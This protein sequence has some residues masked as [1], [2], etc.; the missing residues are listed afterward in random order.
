MIYNIKKRNG[1]WVVDTEGVMLIFESYIAAV[2]TAR[3][4]AEIAKLAVCMI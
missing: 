2:D 1:A 4:A 3:E